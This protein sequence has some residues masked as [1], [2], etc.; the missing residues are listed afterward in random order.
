MKLS[1]PLYILAR[2]SDSRD[3]RDGRMVRRHEIAMHWVDQ[4]RSV[5]L[6][7]ES[8]RRGQCHSKQ[9]QASVANPGEIQQEIPSVPIKITVNAFLGWEGGWLF[10]RRIYTSSP[11]RQGRET[12]IEEEKKPFRN[13]TLQVLQS[14]VHKPCTWVKAILSPGS[15]WLGAVCIQE[16]A[17]YFHRASVA[18][19]S[20]RKNSTPHVRWRLPQSQRLPYP[21]ILTH[22][23]PSYFMVPHSAFYRFLLAQNLLLCSPHTFWLQIPHRNPTERIYSQSFFFIFSLI[24]I[25]LNSSQLDW[26]V[27]E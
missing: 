20:I 14:G 11:E 5:A 25:N 17:L 23:K 21:L 6:R 18:T 3:N 15:R 8:V 13:L 26:R 1:S 24:L 9:L 19:S 16:R 4:E 7:Q 22:L 10:K 2:Y 27:P 12:Q